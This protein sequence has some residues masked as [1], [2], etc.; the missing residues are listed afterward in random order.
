MA[1]KLK[2]YK[3]NN[4]SSKTIGEIY[5]EYLDYCKSIGQRNPLDVISKVNRKIKINRKSTTVSK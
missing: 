4:N 2:T 3:I 5:D 1:F